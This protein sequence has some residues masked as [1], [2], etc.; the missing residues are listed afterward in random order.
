MSAR[1]ASFVRV[2]TSTRREP[3]AFAQNT[4]YT[5][6][7]GAGISTGVLAQRFINRQ[8]VDREFVNRQFVNRQFVNRQFVDTQF[9]D[10]QFVDIKQR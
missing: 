10:T 2:D 1:P 6:C 5:T 3:S 7:V 9:V 8:F 4:R